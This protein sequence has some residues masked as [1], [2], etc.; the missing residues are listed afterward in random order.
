MIEGAGGWWYT[1]AA[2]PRMSRSARGCVPAVKLRLVRTAPA[3]PTPLIVRSATRQGA[4]APHGR[5]HGRSLVEEVNQQLKTTGLQK[6]WDKRRSSDHP[7]WCL[8]CKRC[9]AKR[10]ALTSNLSGS[11]YSFLRCHGARELCKK[12]SRTP[13]TERQAD[14]VQRYLHFGSQP[15]PHASV[16]DNNLSCYVDVRH[17]L[18]CWKGG[19]EKTFELTREVYKYWEVRTFLRPRRRTKDSHL[20]PA[21]NTSATTART[22]AAAPTAASTFP[23]VAEPA[24]F[25]MAP[26]SA[27]RRTRTMTYPARTFP[28]QR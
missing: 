8:H 25:P 21:P 16:D 1:T 24:P 28:G 18:T 13:Y 23:T 27:P 17:A 22:A 19:S 7:L 4:R 6:H 26:N 3:A 2:A 12:R 5:E 20:R 11:G 10:T 15:Q 9:C 14:L